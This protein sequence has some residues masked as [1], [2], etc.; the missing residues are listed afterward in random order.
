MNKE[1]YDQAFIKTF[2]IE[3]VNELPNYM[4]K[5]SPNWDS[6]GH[7]MLCAAIEDAFGIQLDG[8]DILSITSYQEGKSVLSKY[9][10]NID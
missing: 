3:D 6:V 4:I 2:M 8:E 1:K 7:M 9:G 10:L 5:E